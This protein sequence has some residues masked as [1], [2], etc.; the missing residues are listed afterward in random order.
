MFVVYR[1]PCKER[2]QDSVVNGMQ[3]FWDRLLTVIESFYHHYQPR[4]RQL[5]S[6][7]RGLLGPANL[8]D[9]RSLW[10][11]ANRGAFRACL[12]YPCEEWRSVWTG[13]DENS[14]RV[15]QGADL[16]WWFLASRKRST[17]SSD[18]ISRREPNFSRK[19]KIVAMLRWRAREPQSPPGSLRL[20]MMF[21]VEQ[22]QAHQPVNSN[23]Q[24][25]IHQPGREKRN[26]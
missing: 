2:E 3:P 7:F 23:F 19:F 16:S 24:V 25:V 11:V 22:Q 15:D 4:A 13:R 20:W 12:R 17:S 10:I 8:K 6:V 1:V 9:S 21:V 14:V 26:Q 5:D 18:K